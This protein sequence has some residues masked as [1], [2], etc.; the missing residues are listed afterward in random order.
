MFHMLL[1]VAI[2]PIG[3]AP[4]MVCNG[5]GQLAD[6]MMR[7]DPLLGGFNARG[8]TLPSRLRASTQDVAFCQSDLEF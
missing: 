2:E 7:F 1:V 3:A 4:R 8:I 5:V 6:K